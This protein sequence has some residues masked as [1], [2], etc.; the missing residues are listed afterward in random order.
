[1]EK[2]NVHGHFLP[3]RRCEDCGVRMIPME[4]ADGTLLKCSKCGKE[5]NFY[6]EPVLHSLAGLAISHLAAE[7]ISNAV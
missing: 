1:M 3:C 5:K 6:F 7:G 4:T 2:R